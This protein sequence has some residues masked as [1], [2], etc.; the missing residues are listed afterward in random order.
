VQAADNI[1]PDGNAS[2]M[3]VADNISAIDRA[4]EFSLR[5][6]DLD[7]CLFWRKL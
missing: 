3:D 7:D 2:C 4:E 5:D 6:M 1:A